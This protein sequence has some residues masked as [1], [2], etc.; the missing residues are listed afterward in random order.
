[1][2][3]IDRNRNSILEAAERTEFRSSEER[4]EL[5]GVVLI[6][7]GTKCGPYDEMPVELRLLR[8]RENE[9]QDRRVLAYSAGWRVRGQVP[10]DGRE[11]LVEYPYSCD[12]GTVNTTNGLLGI[13]SDGGGDIDWHPN[14]PE[15]AIARDEAVVF[16]VGSHYVSTARSEL[17]N[18]RVVLRTHAAADYRRIELTVGSQ[19]PDFSYADFE[20]QEHR[21]SD[22][23]AQ[24]ILL[25]FWFAAC[26]PC[27]AEIPNMKAALEKYRARGFEVLSLTLDDKEDIENA[28][29][30][31]VKRQMDWPQAAGPNVRDLINQRFQIRAYPNYVLL[32]RRRRIISTGREGESPLRGKPLLE[33]LQKLLP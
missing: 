15:N 21:L 10:I 31:V 5:E 13:D 6:Q 24:Y 8:P 32:D 1:M 23:G 3:Y 25:D 9:S 12:T 16:R 30:V 20:G 27:I 18:R 22:V 4:P 7:L 19:I 14:S 26:G 17:E 33:T 11:V 28:R 2:L 29:Q